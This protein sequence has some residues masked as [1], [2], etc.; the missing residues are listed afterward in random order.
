M[1]KTLSSISK[2]TVAL[3]LTMLMIITFIPFTSVSMQADAASRATVV[4]YM[5]SMAT[6]KW[7]TSKNITYW[8]YVNNVNETRKFSAGVTYTGMPYTQLNRKNLNQFQSQ[9]SGSKY[10]GSTSY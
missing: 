10:I 3:V 5:R 7:S 8:N 1:T 9:L 4:K 2:K 6:I